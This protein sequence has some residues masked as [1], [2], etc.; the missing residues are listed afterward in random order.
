MWI[1]TKWLLQHEISLK[2]EKN[3]KNVAK[4]GNIP[5]EGSIS[6]ENKEHSFGVL[7]VDVLE[8]DRR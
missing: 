3:L 6:Q 4:G 2:S 1:Y 5:R 8:V 7:T